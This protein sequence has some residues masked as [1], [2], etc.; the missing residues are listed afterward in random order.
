M[1]RVIVAVVALV[2]VAAAFA[3]APIKVALKDFKQNP[4][5]TNEFNKVEEEEGKICF[6]AAAIFEASVKIPADGEYELVIKASCDSAKGEKAKYKVY[7]DGKEDGKEVTLTSDDAKDYTR[8]I[9]VKA[10]S[11]KLGIEFTNDIYKEG[12]YDR[13]LYVHEVT[14]K[15]K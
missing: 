12:E 7:L 13:N 3:D 4:K 10:G 8:T 1:K 6:Y 2:A 15:K 5:K 9:K 14:L 11:T